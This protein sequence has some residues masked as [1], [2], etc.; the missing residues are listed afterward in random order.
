MNKSISVASASQRFT[1]Y[2][3][4][5]LALWTI[6]VGTLFLFDFVSIRKEFFSLTR[7]EAIASFN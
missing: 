7:L 5:M 2:T 3:W 6:I 1:R 4:F